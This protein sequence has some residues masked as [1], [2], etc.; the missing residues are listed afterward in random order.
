MDS[1]MDKVIKRIKEV[2]NEEARSFVESKAVY[3][4]SIDIVLDDDTYC[5][6]FTVHGTSGA[7][8]YRTPIL[9]I[10]DDIYIKGQEDIV[11]EDHREYCSN[12][13]YEMS[14][15]ASEEY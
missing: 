11:V 5:M 9:K 2:C 15:L 6:I 13:L 12:I 4:A 3:E 8:I 7:V 14:R 1:Y 10:G